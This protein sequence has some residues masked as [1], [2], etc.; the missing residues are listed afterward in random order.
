MSDDGFG[1]HHYRP[2]E[3]GSIEEYLSRKPLTVPPLFKGYAF[4]EQLKKLG[5]LKPGSGIRLFHFYG[6]DESYIVTSNYKLEGLPGEFGGKEGVHEPKDII[7]D[8]S[9]VWE[10]LE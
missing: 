3:D 10:F 8:D 1:A 6:P 5:R 7:K 9:P 4:F 2:E